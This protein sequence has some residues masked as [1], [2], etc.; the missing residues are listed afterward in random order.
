M[1]S[2]KIYGGPLERL[3]CF[4][5]KE[6]TKNN[7]LI[8]FIDPAAKAGFMAFTKTPLGRRYSA[9][10]PTRS[11]T[12]WC[13]RNHHGITL[14]PTV[15]SATSDPVNPARRALIF[16]KEPGSVLPKEEILRKLRILG[17]VFV[18]QYKVERYQV[19]PENL[20]AFVVFDMIEK[21][22]NIMELYR[23][24]RLGIAL[25]DDI[26]VVYGNDPCDRPIPMSG[27]GN[28]T[29]STNLISPI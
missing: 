28:V 7:F 26:E 27:D 15:I 4:P 16:R 3:T 13:D 5:N 20:E 18:E 1:V 21:A 14:N 25:F 6:K 9:L 11:N 2:A 24:R 17:C 12:R 22:I 29:G 10:Q 8:N 23:G 19:F